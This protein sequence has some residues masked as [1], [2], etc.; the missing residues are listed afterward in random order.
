MPIY[1]HAYATGLYARRRGNVRM[2][3]EHLIEQA[4][5]AEPTGAVIVRAVRAYACLTDSGQWIEPVA[6]VE[7]SSQSSPSAPPPSLQ[8]PPGLSAPQS[9]APSNGFGLPGSG[10]SNRKQKLLESS[11]SDSKQT[12]EVVSN[13]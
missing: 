4:D 10:I 9:V 8:E 3:L 5:A 12:P 6:R 2:S 13:R 11:V 1:R 7:F